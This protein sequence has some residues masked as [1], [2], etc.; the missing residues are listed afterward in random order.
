MKTAEFRIRVWVVAFA[1]LG[2]VAFV[3]VTGSTQS[4]V[5][6]AST[7]VVLG[8]TLMDGTGADPVTDSVVVIQG[9]RIV[10][11]GPRSEVNVPRGARVVDARG[12]CIIPGLIDA[13]VHFIQSGG[14]YTRP[15]IVDL[16]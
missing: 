1:L 5:R 2:A 13:H 6:S 12:K 11:V 15:D 3:V 9:E 4:G 8:G 7:V 16:R 14:L 10:A